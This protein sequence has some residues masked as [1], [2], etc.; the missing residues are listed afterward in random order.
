VRNEFLTVVRS[1]TGRVT[2]SS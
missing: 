2:L 1:A